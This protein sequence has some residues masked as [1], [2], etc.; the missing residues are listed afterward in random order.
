MCREVELNAQSKRGGNRQ[1][2][3]A[4]DSKRLR[5]RRQMQMNLM[6][7]PGYLAQLVKNSHLASRVGTFNSSINLPPWY[8]WFCETHIIMRETVNKQ[9]N[10][11]VYNTKGTIRQ[12]QRMN[13]K[14]VVVG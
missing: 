6:T 8:S 5:F 4:S 7:A 2:A 9:I 10:T 1:R 13:T 3:K 12:K 11:K 14:I